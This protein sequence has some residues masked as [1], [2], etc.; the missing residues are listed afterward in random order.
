MSWSTEFKEIVENERIVYTE[1]YDGWPEGVT[2]VTATFG[3]DGSTTTITVLTEYLDQATRDLAMQPGF[4]EGFAASYDNLDPILA[5]LI[6]D[7]A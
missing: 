6:L 2:T 5:T 3:Q 4:E 7:E 1:L